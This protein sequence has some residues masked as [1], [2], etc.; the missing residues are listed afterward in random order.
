MQLGLS[1]EIVL[2][3][4]IE[5]SFALNKGLSITLPVF[6]PAIL[7]TLIASEVSDVLKSFR[8]PK[9]IILKSLSVAVGG[10]SKMCN[11]TLKSGVKETDAVG[12][13]FWGGKLIH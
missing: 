6:S 9:S 8:K 3:V 7:I 2:P 1:R 12:E 5:D 11:I 10:V 13:I 4:V